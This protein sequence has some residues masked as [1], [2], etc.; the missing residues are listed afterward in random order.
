MIH[1]LARAFHV[2][3]IALAGVPSTE[4][5]HPTQAPASRPIKPRP[6]TPWSVPQASTSGVRGA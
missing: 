5:E 3:D 4:R 1:H 2:R 6:I